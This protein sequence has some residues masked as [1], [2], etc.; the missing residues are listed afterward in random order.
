MAAEQQDLV[1]HIAELVDRA[2]I[3][4]LTKSGTPAKLVSRPIALQEV[5]FDGDLWFFTYD[6]SHRHATSVGTARSMWRSRTTRTA[7]GLRCRGRLRSCTTGPR[8][9]SC[10]RLC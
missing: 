7:S 8:L 5:E 3:S 9:R 10:G 1:Q 4:M 2:K 6:D